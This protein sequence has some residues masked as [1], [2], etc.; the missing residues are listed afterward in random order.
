[1]GVVDHHWMSMEEILEGNLAMGVVTIGVTRRVLGSGRGAE[2][3]VRGVTMM[4]TGTVATPRI[5]AGMNP[6]G[7]VKIVTI[8]MGVKME[9]G[10]ER[11]IVI[12]PPEVGNL[13]GTEIEGTMIIEIGMIIEIV[14]VAGTIKNTM[15]GTGD[16]TDMTTEMMTGDET[17]GTN[18]EMM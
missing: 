14:T 15:I 8:A 11:D 5:E 13:T 2:A 16:E 10:L 17:I 9:G 18:I 1:M 4:G 7:V 3:L 12:G 6:G